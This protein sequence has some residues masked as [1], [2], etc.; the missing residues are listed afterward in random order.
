MKPSSLLLP[1]SFIVALSV[2]PF[3]QAQV[4]FDSG[5][6]TPRDAGAGTREVV[7]EERAAQRNRARHPVVNGKV[8]CRDG[9]RHIARVCGRHGGIAGR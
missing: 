1:L 6:A 5:S 2:A 9:S 7:R 4:H 8:R 3:S